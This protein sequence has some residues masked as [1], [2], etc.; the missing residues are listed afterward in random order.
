VSLLR[1]WLPKADGPIWSN[2]DCNNASWNL[3]HPVDESRLPA[4]Q[5]VRNGKVKTSIHS[6]TIWSLKILR[7][8]QK[9]V[10]RIEKTSTEMKYLE[11]NNQH[12]FASWACLSSWQTNPNGKY[13]PGNFCSFLQMCKCLSQSGGAK[14]NMLNIYTVDQSWQQ[15]F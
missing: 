1:C 4:H 15:N 9:E 3:H 7:N 5:V 8:G 12:G 14:N 10:I 13:L 6:R 11:F 2:S